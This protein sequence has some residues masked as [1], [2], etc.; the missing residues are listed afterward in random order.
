MTTEAEEVAKLARNASTAHALKTADGREYLIY[1]KDYEAR[2]VTEAYGLKH[3]RPAYVHQHVLLQQ[4]DSLVEYVRR[5]KTAASLLFADIDESAIV[6]VID[7]HDAAN[8]PD[9]TGAVEP[10]SQANHGA[11]KASMVLPLSEEWKCWKKI[12]GML[13]NQLAFARHIEE[14]APDIKA[15]PAGELFDAIRDLQAHRKVSFVAAVRT[16]SNNQDFAYEEETNATTR[17]GNIELPHAFLLSIPVYFGEPATELQAFLRWKLDDGAL[18]LGVQLYR[19]EYVR[20]AA[21]RLIVT[22]V[23]EAT[24]CPV[25]FGKPNK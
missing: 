3:K 6:A 15:P 11:H 7:Y 14:N 12:D 9:A 21:F 4:R 25:V 17:K 18:V 20:Q 5:F 10:A 19:A 1:P 24:G 22:Q 2:D 8:G 13:Q 16:A 23:A